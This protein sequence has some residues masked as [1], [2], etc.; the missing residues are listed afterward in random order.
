MFF[1][2]EYSILSYVLFDKILRM[3]NFL[4]KNSFVYLFVKIYINIGF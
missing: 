2:L 1:M 3:N 4:K